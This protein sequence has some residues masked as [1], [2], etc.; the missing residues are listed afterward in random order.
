MRHIAFIGFGEAGT[1]LA[2][3]LAHQHRVVVWDCK[4]RGGDREAML[5]KAER[6]GVQ[7]AGSLLGVG[8]MIKAYQ[9]AD[10]GRVSVIEYVILPA[11]AF[12]SWAIWGQTLGLLAVAGMGLIAAAGMMIALRAQSAR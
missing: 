9:L 2:S 10:A 8:M 11:S 6:A 7:A 4:L 3:E 1:I 5:A 12:W